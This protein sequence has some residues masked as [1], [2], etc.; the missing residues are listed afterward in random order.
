[1]NK[2]DGDGENSVQTK[3]SVSDF[4]REYSFPS[5][6]E[7][8]TSRKIPPDPNDSLSPDRQRKI[9][10]LSKRGHQLLKS[11]KFQPARDVFEQACKMDGQNPYILSGLAECLKHL[12]QISEAIACYEKLLA[13]EPDNRFALRGLGDLCKL[14]KDYDR[15]ITLWFEYLKYR[16]NDIF[17][18]TRIADA[19]KTLNRFEEAEDF[20]RKVLMLNSA[21]QYSLMGLADLYHKTSREKLAIEYYEKVLE[22]SP[23]LINILTIVGNLYRQ[24]EDFDKARSFFVRALKLEPKNSYAL[25]GLGHCHR[26]NRDYAQ[27]IDCWEPLLQ[28]EVVTNSMLSRLGDMYRNLGRFQDAEKTYL[29]GLGAGYDR[30]PQLGLMKLMCLQGREEEVC[31][32]SDEYFSREGFDLET[33]KELT[34]LFLQTGRK[35]AAARFYHFILIRSDLTSGEISQI[36]GRLGKLAE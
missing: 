24:L 5:R 17:V 6:E 25:Y 15:A 3:K 31:R 32:L 11:K 7:K 33:V 12:G 19:L 34:E 29:R 27:A 23:G 13:L 8:P 20:Y 21:D 4:T 2:S 30:F 26:W 16:A 36:E 28:S 9:V 10:G 22:K 14:R 1:M 35:E 18:L